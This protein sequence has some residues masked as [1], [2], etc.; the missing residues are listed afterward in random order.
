MSELDRDLDR[1]AEATTRL[2]DVVSRLGQKDL[3]RALGDGWTVGFALAHLAFWDARQ[4]FAL[5]RFARGEGFPID[6]TVTNA[7]LESLASVFRADS[8]GAAAVGAAEQLDTT[9]RS[10]TDGQRSSLRDAGFE[11]AIKRWPHREEHLAQVEDRLSA[12]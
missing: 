1:N 7:T 10:L 5:Q 2:R 12:L 6:D 9:A 11:Y 8:A 4:H 3:E